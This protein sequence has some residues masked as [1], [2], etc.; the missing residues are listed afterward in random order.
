MNRIDKET[1]K[2]LADQS[3]ESII[4]T[5]AQMDMVVRDFKAA[6]GFGD[7]LNWLEFANRGRVWATI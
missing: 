5:Q 6:Q 1:T 3:S 2:R 4:Q 7:K